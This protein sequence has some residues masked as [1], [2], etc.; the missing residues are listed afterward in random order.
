M[1]RDWHIVFT[2]A[3]ALLAY[4]PVSHAQVA[5]PR[6]G[7]PVL[8]NVGVRPVTPPVSS[9]FNSIHGVVVDQ[10]GKPL[11]RVRVRVIGPAMAVSATESTGHFTVASLPPGQYVVRAF[12]L[13]YSV[14]RSQRLTLDAGLAPS[15]RLT[16]VR[17]ARAGGPESSSAGI[18]EAGAGLG[19]PAAPRVVETRGTTDS[20]TPDAESEN[21][22]ENES[23]I[24]DDHSETAWRLR[25]LDRSPLKDAAANTAVVDSLDG[26]DSDAITILQ[27]AMDTSARVASALFDL[28]LSGQV[29]LLASGAFDRPEQLLSTNQ[30]AQSTAYVSLGSDAGDL[31]NWAVRGAMMQGDVS[32]WIVAGFIVAPSANRH[33]Y[34]VGMSYSTQRQDGGQGTALKVA[35]TRN[36]AGAYGFDRWT[37]SPRLVLDYGARYSRYDY[38]AGSGLLSPRVDV[39]VTPADRLRVTMMAARRTIAPGAD[40]FAPSMSAGFWLPPSRTF[41]PLVDV[42]GFRVE[43]TNHYEIGVERDLSRAIVVAL[44]AYRQDV[45]DQLA[46][47]FDAGGSADDRPAAPGHY[48]VATAGDVRVGGWTAGISHVIGTV[49]STLEYSQTRADWSPSRFA[50]AI[51]VAGASAVRAGAESL[52]DFTASVRAEVPQIATRVFVLCRVNS[53]LAGVEDT[54]GAARFDV[55]INQPLPFL[56]FNDAQWE[57]LLNVRNLFRDPETGA[58]AYDEILV[59]HPPKRI[60]GGILLRF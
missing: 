51:A 22:S 40:E 45:N 1:N 4:P 14:A 31:G 30:F 37:V 55:Q 43:G 13:G 47:I 15:L 48:H 16:M 46:T 44:R 58:S 41:S 26:R 57:M 7:W 35:G 2:A 5:L 38:L 20:Q 24:R 50:D 19:A 32:S 53:G 29:N 34:D 21:E 12:L 39:T 8:S 6:G 42:D 54:W 18:I 28:S 27:R 36:A 59:L 17:E 56:N 33:A 3:L 23:M 49:H 10:S 9:G 11:P 60:V 52:S 25:H